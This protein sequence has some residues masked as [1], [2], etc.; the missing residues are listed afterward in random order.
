MYKSIV[1]LLFIGLMSA[2]A[3][4][5]TT[6][7]SLDALISE[8]IIAEFDPENITPMRM[9][10]A[11]AERG[12]IVQHWDL[13]VTIE[14]PHTYHLHFEV[15][16]FPGGNPTITSYAWDAGQFS[17]LH[18]FFGNHVAEGDF[19]A[20]LTFDVPET[21]AIARQAL[22]LERS[23][24]EANFALENQDRL[25]EIADLR[26]QI[27]FA[28]EGE[29]EVIALRL[30]R[31]ELLH[32]QFTTNVNNRR[33]HFA[34]RLDEINAPIQTERLYA[35]VAGR[36]IYTT[37]HTQAGLFRDVPNI[38]FGSHGAV[39]RRVAS[40]VDENS[41]HFIAHAPLYALRY[42]DIV[43]VIRLGGESSFFAMVAT[44]PMTGNVNR[45]GSFDVR[46]IPLPGEME[47]F[48]QQLEDELGENFRENANILNIMQLR[49]RPQVPLVTNGV[50]ISRHAV[51]EENHRH[52]VM[53]HNDGIV[54]KRYV[55]VGAVSGNQ[56]QIL[57]GLEP[58]QWVVLP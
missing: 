27:E 56:I 47:R 13:P 49:V 6:D 54:G 2:C 21:I 40:I 24:F 46:L 1:L 30:E 19:I 41:M 36:V 14:F 53:V 57:S 31:A 18:V 52:F 29:W 43:P 39:G 51:T 33:E 5:V 20:E 42:G 34:A 9:N 35:P 55:T 11:Q 45:D 4:Q 16:T 12:D 50:L 25:R 7:N 8:G 3:T 37:Q 28:P 22:E 48:I 38:T 32:R 17:G 58:G 26:T 23:S 44:D 10:F 15:E